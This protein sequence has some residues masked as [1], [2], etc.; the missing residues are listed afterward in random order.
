M[1]YTKKNLREVN[2][3]AAAQGFG[4]IQEARFARG[5]LDAADTGL[6][7]H[8]LR[9]GKRQFAHRHHNAEEIVVVLSGSGRAKLN[10]ELV[11]LETMDALRLPPETVRA[12]EA[13]PEGLEML[14]FGPHHEKDAQ[15]IQEDVWGD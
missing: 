13:G 2:D 14:V 1:S 10:D 12:F 15:I 4:E 3:M 5:D 6:A 8:V 11:D 9:P 7:Y